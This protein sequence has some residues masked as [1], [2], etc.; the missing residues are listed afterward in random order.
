MDSSQSGNSA[1]GACDN[2]EQHE[3]VYVDMN[4]IE[5]SPGSS[6]SSGAS[7][8]VDNDSRDPGCSEDVSI[9]LFF[10]LI[11]LLLAL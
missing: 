10:Y 5:L 11:M 4:Q 8:G 3:A 7:K 9:C 1:I 6:P 2:V